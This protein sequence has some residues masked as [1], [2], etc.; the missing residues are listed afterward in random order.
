M[1]IS[2]FIILPEIPFDTVILSTWRRAA[3][4]SLYIELM[5][6]ICTKVVS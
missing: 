1:V 2:V 4:T 5:S 6:Y 3:T